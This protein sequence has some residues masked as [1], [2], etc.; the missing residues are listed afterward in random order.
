MRESTTPESGEQD[1]DTRQLDYLLPD[2]LEALK[3][4]FERGRDN[5]YIAKDQA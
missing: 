1:H 4:Y 5:K 2:W 3:H